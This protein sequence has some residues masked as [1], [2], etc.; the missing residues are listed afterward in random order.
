VMSAVKSSADAGFKNPISAANTA[1]Q[2]FIAQ[3]L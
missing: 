2:N 3:L 1:A